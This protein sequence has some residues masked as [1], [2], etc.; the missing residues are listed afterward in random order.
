M[1]KQ[2]IITVLAFLLVVGGAYAADKIINIYMGADD[3]ELVE[4]YGASSDF[5]DGTEAT[6]NLCNVDVHTLTIDRSYDG[7]ME[8]GSLTAATS[9]GG[10]FSVQNDTGADLLCREVTIDVTTAPSY[11]GA[12]FSVTTSTVAYANDGASNA[13]PKLIATSTMATSTPETFTK[14]DEVGSDDND[15]WT[16][17]DDEY[18]VGSMDSVVPTEASS[19]DWIDVAGKYYIHCW[20]K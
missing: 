14:T 4:S 5:C 16:W 13:L 8:T 18:I 11:K 6:T 9:S 17:D 7:F 10:L 15:S 12:Y 2:I 3:P 19:T 20:M 1:K